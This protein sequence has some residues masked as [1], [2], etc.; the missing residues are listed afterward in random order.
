MDEE[1]KKYQELQY[2][3]EQRKVNYL[4][5]IEEMKQEHKT[6]KEK[7][8]DKYQSQISHAY[9]KHEELQEHLEMT[10]SEF[11]R[12]VDIILDRNKEIL[13]NIQREYEDKF[14][15]LETVNDKLGGDMKRLILYI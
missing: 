3:H 5:V 4:K 10:K 15:Q 7:M 2:A 11:R 1:R 14:Q 9:D 8:Q 13:M 6:E 12:E